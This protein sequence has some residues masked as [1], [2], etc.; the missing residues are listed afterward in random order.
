MDRY[1]E[2]RTQLLDVEDILWK[3][4]E[5]DRSA[6]KRAIQI[7][8]AVRTELSDIKDYGVNKDQWPIG[9]LKV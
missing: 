6:C 7:I 2:L 8:E 4:Y 3:V 5:A 1:E 9:K